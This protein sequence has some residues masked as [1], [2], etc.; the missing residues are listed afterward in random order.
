MGS[1]RSR[2][3]RLSIWR[4][5]NLVLEPRGRFLGERDAAINRLNKIRSVAGSAILIGITVYYSGLTHLATVS[6]DRSGT[7]VISVT[8][9]TPETHWLINVL[10]FVVSVMC[11][12]P[13]VSG[14]LVL[15]A[16]REARW[17]TFS[18]LRWPFISIAAWFGILAVSTPII[19]VASVFASRDTNGA[20]WAVRLGAYAFAIF[21][22]VV[23]LVWVSKAVYLA[24]TGLFCADD[25]HPLLAPVVAPCAAW[26]TVGLMANYGSDGVGRI[27]RVIGL[28][29]GYGGASSITALSLVTCYLLRR[30]YKSDFPF[31]SGPIADRPTL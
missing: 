8:N 25:G 24:A 9:N 27:P 15:W 11:L 6:V 28:L 13:V 29:L 10:V 14:I 1:S 12:M 20:S 4:V 26:L 31:R 2:I 18:H 17:A 16:K 22:G 30:K 7:R 21:V 5:P 3:G 23:M 19:T